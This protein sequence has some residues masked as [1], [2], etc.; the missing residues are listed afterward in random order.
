M[1]CFAQA[2]N[3]LTTFSSLEKFRSPQTR[4]FVQQVIEEEEDLG[5]QG[6]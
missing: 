6:A 4:A 5:Q 2:Q 1:P 3:I